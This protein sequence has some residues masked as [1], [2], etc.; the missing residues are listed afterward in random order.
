MCRP[1]PSVEPEFVSKIRIT[2]VDVDY[3]DP[4]REHLFPGE[5]LSI[6]VH[7]E[8]DEPIDDIVFAL[9]ILDQR[10]T[11]LLGTNTD[12]MGS[13]IDSIGTSGEVVFDLEQIPLLDGVYNIGVGACTRDGGTIYADR[14]EKDN[15]SVMNS[16]RN[17]GLVYF[18]V[19]ARLEDTDPGR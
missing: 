14:A 4:L 12:V 3:P 7:F 11:Y 19:K 2:R 8:T 1:K 13:P 5:P 18:P 9:T 10:G 16:T 6:R 17:E 15:F